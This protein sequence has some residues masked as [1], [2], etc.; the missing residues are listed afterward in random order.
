MNLFRAYSECG[1][2]ATGKEDE[3]MSNGHQSSSEGGRAPISHFEAVVIGAGFS[4]LYMLYRLRELGLS[5]QVY[6]AG[7]GYG[8]FRALS[9]CGNRS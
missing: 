7:E 6:E 1:H 5:T 9:D 4:G 8:R 2:E 3:V